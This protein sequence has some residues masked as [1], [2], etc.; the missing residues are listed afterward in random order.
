VNQTRISELVKVN[1]FSQRLDGVFQVDSVER[2][3]D[4]SDGEIIDWPTEY[5]L[6]NSRANLLRPL[7]LRAANHYDNG[8]VRVL[9][10][11]CGCGS[12]TRYLGEQEG[13]IV[14]SVEGSPSR[15]GLAA[16]RCLKTIMI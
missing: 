7:N 9:E 12:I 3:F 6:S 11:G 15:A 10:I 16:L 2:G 5:H 13:F 8:E 14:D 4:Y 1:G